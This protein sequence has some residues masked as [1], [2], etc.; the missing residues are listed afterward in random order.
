MSTCV[1]CLS[2]Q[3]ADDELA[4]TVPST[5]SEQISSAAGQLS[6]VGVAKHNALASSSSGSGTNKSGGKGERSYL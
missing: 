5:A 3:L 2:G 1:E 6:P 4:V